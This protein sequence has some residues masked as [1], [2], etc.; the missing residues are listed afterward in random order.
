MRMR[1]HYIIAAMGVVLGVAVAVML[2]RTLP[3]DRASDSAALDPT[4]PAIGPKELFEWQHAERRK[5]D[6]FPLTASG[7]TPDESLDQLVDSSTS[8]PSRVLNPQMRNELISTIAGHLRARAEESADFYMAL[9]EQEPTRFIGPE[10]DEN[11]W[12]TVQQ[13]YAWVTDGRQARRDD[14]RGAL[15]TSFSFW[16][17]ESKRRLTGVGVGPR[18]MRID[19]IRTRNVAELASGAAFGVGYGAPDVVETRFWMGGG[20]GGSPLFRFPLVPLQEVIDK[21][22]SAVVAQSLLTVEDVSGRRYP[23]RTIWYWIPERSQWGTEGMITHG[24]GSHSILY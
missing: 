20:G 19:V 9:A 7:E 15:R 8:D 24:A 4:A 10:D 3:D 6:I 12:R 17:G 13:H 5:I 23:W 14:A 2:S 18:G 21:N 16:L 1:P 11:A 22:G